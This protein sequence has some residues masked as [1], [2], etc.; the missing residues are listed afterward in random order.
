MGLPGLSQSLQGASQHHPASGRDIPPNSCNTLRGH[1]HHHRHRH[2]YR[3]HHHHPWPTGSGSE[4]SFLSGSSSTVA[5][6]SSQLLG[7]V[8][9]ISGAST[10]CHGSTLRFLLFEASS[11]L[12]DCMFSNLAV[13]STVLD[14]SPVVI[15]KHPKASQ[16]PPGALPKMLRMFLNVFY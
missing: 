8:M 11:Q 6:P 16:E 5:G 13:A 10:R 9:T 1:R 2:H 3:H 4:S 12:L 7:C 15:K 14:A